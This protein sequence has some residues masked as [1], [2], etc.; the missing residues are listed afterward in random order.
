MKIVD[1]SPTRV[2]PLGI[3]GEN[4]AI[5]VSF[6]LT[7]Y[8]STYGDGQVQLLVQRSDDNLPYPVNLK[9]KDSCALWEV[10]SLDTSIPGFG[11]AELRWI[12]GETVVKSNAYTFFVF[13]SVGE[14]SDP[15]EMWKSWLDELLDAAADVQATVE[16]VLPYIDAETYTWHIWS[17]AESRYIDTGISARGEDGLRGPPGAPGATG[18]QGD[19]GPQGPKGDK[20]DAFTYAD[21]TPEQLAALKGEKGDTGATGPQGPKGDT[22]ATGP[23]GEPGEVGP[24]GPKGDKGDPGTVGPAGAD[25]KD[26]APGADGHTPEYGVDYG[27]PE[28]IAEI[29]QSAAEILQPEINRLKNDLSALGLS[30]VDGM[31]CQTYKEG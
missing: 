25:G 12:A 11:K 2:I 21:F 19:S 17:A 7:G 28:Q 4:I 13:E 24:Q 22:G 9:I 14:A 1:A 20:G 15:P 18:P 3:Q 6:D 30:V 31:I 10:S 26:G 23:K 27:T 8:Y 16:N 29:A 5:A